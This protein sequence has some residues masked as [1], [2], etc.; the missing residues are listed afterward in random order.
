MSF[1]RLSFN[2]YYSL[3]NFI[4]IN[5]F[6]TILYSL[7]FYFESKMLIYEP[8]FLW[9]PSDSDITGQPPEMFHLSSALTKVAFFFPKV[10]M[11]GFF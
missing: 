10:S 5:Y 2:I 9:W 6:K 8:E 3:H 7:F 11:L 1:I 4:L